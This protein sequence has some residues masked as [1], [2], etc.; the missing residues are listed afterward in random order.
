MK[1]K[2]RGVQPTS[3]EECGSV[4]EANQWWQVEARRIAQ[5]EGPEAARRWVDEK[6]EPWHEEHS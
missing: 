4:F 3:C 5:I 1:L 2:L 6:L